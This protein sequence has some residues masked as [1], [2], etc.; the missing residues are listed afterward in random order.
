MVEQYTT[1]PLVGIGTTR[2]NVVELNAALAR[3][4]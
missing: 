1:Y 3:K 2:V 4:R